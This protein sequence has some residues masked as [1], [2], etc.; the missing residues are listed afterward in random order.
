MRS[1]VK[2]FL[3]VFKDKR[4]VY[5]DFDRALSLVMCKYSMRF[6]KR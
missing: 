1:C 2:Y 3:K 5:N 6:L 4:E